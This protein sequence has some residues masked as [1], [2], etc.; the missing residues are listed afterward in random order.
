M[1]QRTRNILYG[2]SAL[3]FAIIAK[4]LAT[5]PGSNAELHSKCYMI[6]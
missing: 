5:P 6:W 2:A 4:T 1:E 3:E